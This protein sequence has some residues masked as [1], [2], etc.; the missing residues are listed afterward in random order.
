MIIENKIIIDELR[1]AIKE[2]FIKREE[3][4]MSAIDAL[5]VGPRF[6]T[7][8]E[9]TASPY[10]KYQWVSLF[11]GIRAG[12]EEQSLARLRRRRLNWLEQ[13]GEKI[14]EPQSRLGDWQVRILDASNYDRPKAETVERSFVHGAEGMKVGHCLS[15]LG[16]YVTAGSWVLPLEIKLV[17]NNKTAREF[18]PQQM[19]DFVKQR[20]WPVNYVLAV[21]ADYTKEP[22]LRP[23]KEAG[24]NV[25][26]RVSHKRKFYL[27]PP[28][29]AGR[30]RP[31]VRGRKIKLKD[32]RTLP[33]PD[34]RERVDLVSG[35]YCEVSCWLDM[36]MFAW[37]EQPLVLYRVVEYRAD[38]TL[39]YKRPLWLIYLQANGAIPTPA[40]AQ[41]IY[42]C[43]FGIEHN[44]RFLKSELGLTSGQ[45]NG[46]QARERIALWVELVATAFWQL[47]AL[48]AQA[49]SETAQLPR[50]WHN[51]TLTP[52]AVHRVALALF[53]KIGI[54]PFKPK[55]RGKSPGRVFG[56]L[57]EP[58]RRFKIFRK[59]K[60]KRAA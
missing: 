49:Q 50:W 2:A 9:M 22:V 58:R 19:V 20:P 7:P 45:F 28:P 59:R 1:A 3:L 16:E 13:Y 31:P 14:G 11:S 38:G 33:V 23:M 40:Q 60:H 57:F 48:K 5:T 56:T 34:Q 46:E 12:K 35:R 18:G 43:R 24:I 21:D 44:I 10:W 41:A 52:G 53:V 8:V 51:K 29:Y 54:E 30:G 26:G 47:A 39:R 27:P 36:R 32:A 4:L 37:P 42:D 55:P 6:S 15:I 25:L 17:D